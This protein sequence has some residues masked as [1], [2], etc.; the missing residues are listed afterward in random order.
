M[1]FRKKRSNS[2]DSKDLQDQ[3]NEASMEDNIGTEKIV[4]DSAQSG[5]EAKIAL[6]EEVLRGTEY[7][8]E[9]DMIIKYIRSLKAELKG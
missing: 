9:R 1:F 5:I 8:E 6:Y 4:V 7:P 2:L 3:S